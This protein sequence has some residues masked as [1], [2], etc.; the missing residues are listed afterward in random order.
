MS[1]FVRLIYSAH[2]VI[3]WTILSNILFHRLEYLSYPNR[4]IGS[5]WMPNQ[6][7]QNLSQSVIFTLYNFARNCV[8][9]TQSFSNLFRIMDRFQQLDVENFLPI[10]IKVELPGRCSGKMCNP[11]KDMTQFLRASSLY[12]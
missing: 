8:D 3:T 6:P 9:V 2:L 10:V 4:I 11:V 5:M 12:I 7:L 1:C